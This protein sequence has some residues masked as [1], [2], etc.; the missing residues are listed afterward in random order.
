MGVPSIARSSPTYICRWKTGGPTCACEDRLAH[1][2][3]NYVSVISEGQAGGPHI[4]APSLFPLRLLEAQF[5]TT[6]GL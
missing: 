1:G 3:G 6:P 4:Q 5:P 2:L